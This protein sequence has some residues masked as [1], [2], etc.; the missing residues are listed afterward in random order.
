M[1]VLITNMHPRGGG[2]H[3]RYI[4]YLTKLDDIEIHIAAPKCSA[5]YNQLKSTNYPRLWACDFPS[6]FFR[7]FMPMMYAVK[8]L[9]EIISTIEPEI[10]HV[11]AGAD[12]LIAMIAHP[13]C[14]SYKIIRTHHAIR[15]INKD[16]YHYFL[17][18]KIIAANIYVSRPAKN[19]AL[20]KG[21][22]VMNAT[23]I[24][25]GVD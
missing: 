7:E 24:N 13:F 15:H 25:N 2:G 18:N 23:V 12:Q 8:K 20:S 11:N 22:Q 10:V 5:I 9:K 4:S 17:Y 1:K 14:P 19:L 3:D 21:L 6:N 16:L